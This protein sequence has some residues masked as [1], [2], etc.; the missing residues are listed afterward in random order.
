MI[1]LYAILGWVA[2]DGFTLLAWYLLKK[3]QYL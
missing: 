1:W 2:A 3:D